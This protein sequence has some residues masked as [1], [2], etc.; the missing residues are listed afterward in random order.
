MLSPNVGVRSICRP[1]EGVS[2]QKS[3][4]CRRTVR[5]FPLSKRRRSHRAFGKRLQRFGGVRLCREAYSPVRSHLPAN[6]VNNPL[7]QQ[8]AGPPAC[9]AGCPLYVVDCIGR[10]NRPGG[11]S[12]H[13]RPLIAAQSQRGF[14]RLGA[15]RY[16]CRRRGLDRGRPCRRGRPVLRKG[17]AVPVPRDRRCRRSAIV[18]AP[19]RPHEKSCSRAAISTASKSRSRI[20]WRRPFAPES[21]SRCVSY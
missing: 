5:S 19:V 14:L 15:V 4:H 1:F 2:L 7:C 6:S 12:P 18:P 20:D 8:E 17:T 10:M 9:E 21:K 13:S 16:D 3:L 11:L